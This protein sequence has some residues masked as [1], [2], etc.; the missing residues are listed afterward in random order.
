MIVNTLWGPEDIPETRRCCDCN[1]VKPKTEF[2]YRGFRKDGSKEFRN[3]CKRCNQKKIKFSNRYRR[4]IPLPD[5]NYCCPICKKTE[6][7][8][9]TLFGS[10]QTLSNKGGDG[11]TIWCCDHDHKTL[12][13]RAYICNYCNIVIGRVKDNPETLENAAKYLRSFQ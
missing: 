2:S 5:E 7:E 12:K 4:S 3:D 11:R 8:I 10:Y 13:F 6:K 1:E 9:K